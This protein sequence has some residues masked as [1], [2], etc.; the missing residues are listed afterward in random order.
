ME[1]PERFVPSLIRFQRFQSA[2]FCC[3]KPL[4]EFSTL[5]ASRKKHFLA[6]G[7]GKVDI[8]GIAYA[9]PFGE[10]C[11]ENVE[12]AADNVDVSAGLYNE[13]ERKR[14]FLNRCYEALWRSRIKIN[15]VGF[16]VVF[17]PSVDPFLK[18]WELGYGPVNASLSM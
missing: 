11:G 1:G 7:D 10:D 12:T 3:G 2:T 15:D 17:D 14:L 13:A 6:G 18:G 9:E 8:F 16:D 5:I 4:Y